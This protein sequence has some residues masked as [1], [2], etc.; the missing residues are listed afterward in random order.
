M[1][2]YLPVHLFLSARPQRHRHRHFQDCRPR[3][4]F[5]DEPDLF[6][7]YYFQ[8]LY[9]KLWQGPSQQYLS[10]WKRPQL[11]LKKFFTRVLTWKS[12]PRARAHFL[13]FPLTLVLPILAYTNRK[14]IQR[15]LAFVVFRQCRQ[16]AYTPS[17]VGSDVYFKRVLSGIIYME[18]KGDLKVDWSNHYF[19]P[20]TL[21]PCIQ[22]EDIHDVNHS[23]F[24]GIFWSTLEGTGATTMR[25]S[26]LMKVTVV[27]YFC[28]PIS[29][30]PKYW[31]SAGL[32]SQVNKMLWGHLICLI[33]CPPTYLAY[34]SLV[35]L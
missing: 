2:E 13:Q 9:F 20:K 15:F 34:L 22:T 6:L 26:G 25:R 14:V 1:H 5:Y 10:G 27:I 4:S 7:N 3:K 11:L 18:Y 30:I 32:C 24:C 33:C 35:G 28:E 8:W 23:P 12:Y 17:N 21:L 31:I 29:W 19:P 16:R